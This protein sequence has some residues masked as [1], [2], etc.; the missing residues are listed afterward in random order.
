[1]SSSPA[2][3]PRLLPGRSALE[4]S[5]FSVVVY[6]AL[7][8]TIVLEVAYAVF[9]VH[10]RG[11]LSA[12]IVATHSLLVASTLT[13]LILA[14]IV[15]SRSARERLAGY[16]TAIALDQDLDLL[17]Y[18]TGAV[19]RQAGAPLFRSRREFRAARLRA[20]E[21]GSRNV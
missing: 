14:R 11:W 10:P 12:A 18:Q 17:D 20:A 1:M 4:W 19:L 15:R 16:T 2:E 5:Q 3:A 13:A 6:V 7:A 21:V 9:H 8:I